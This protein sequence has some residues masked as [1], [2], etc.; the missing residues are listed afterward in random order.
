[1]I[2][3]CKVIEDLLP[4][5]ADGICSEDTKTVVEHHTAECADCRKK[6]E[7]MTSD[8]VE[9]E[10]SGEKKPSPE[11]PF[12][13]LRRHYT[14]LVVCTLLICAAVLIPS[15]LVF[16]LYINEETNQGMSF[17]SIAV[18]RELKKFGN[19]F[20]RG[21]YRK[22]LESVE[23]YYQDGYTPAE[24]AA[25]KNMFAADLE[26]YYK[27]YPIKKVK[28]EA[29][30][31]KSDNGTVWLYLD[32]E[33]YKGTDK[34]PVQYIYFEF[35]KEDDGSRTMILGGCESWVENTDYDRE[36]NVTFP[37]LPLLPINRSEYIFDNFKKEANHMFLFLFH[38]AETIAFGDE[39]NEDGVY[40]EEVVS[41]VYAQKLQ[42]LLWDYSY[43]G[44]ESG[45][46]TY[47]QEDILDMHSYF[48]Q[49]SVLT[50]ST[51]E[52]SEFTA[53]FDVPV[54]NYGAFTHLKNVSYSDNAPDNFKRQFEDIFVNDAPV[55]DQYR[56]Q[57]LNDGKFYL[58]G[59]TESCYYEIM[60]GKM[61]FVVENE[62]QARELFDAETANADNEAF[63][64]LSYDGWY[65][66]ASVRWDQTAEYY[67]IIPG[68]TGVR[69]LYGYYSDDDGHNTGHR[70]AGYF[71]SD[72]IVQNNCIFTRV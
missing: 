52:G 39:K 28:V 48:I 44:C 14:R 35:R 30:D 45:T 9:T 25:F 66:S 42:K 26:E 5:Y 50:M 38:T 19:M 8:T 64:N 11:N 13:K 29:A 36:L 7:A 60:D 18:S 68:G 21:E 61:Q 41:C 40:K 22:A 17:S 69:I 3:T 53:E 20:K 4:L 57:K 27:T 46:M 59:N 56:E 15:A 34:E 71:D 72:H 55:Y 65:S 2:V 67:E 58:N 63:R 24:I 31:G 32:A 37:P 49:H 23:L 51:A 47:V 12:K 6:L 70:S 10:K 1:M 62:E 33:K 43:I 54:L 16:R